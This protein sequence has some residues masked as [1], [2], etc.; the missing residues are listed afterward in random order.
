MAIILLQSAGRYEDLKQ[1]EEFGHT[2]WSRCEPG[3]A[4]HDVFDRHIC[5]RL[6]QEGGHASA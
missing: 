5:C 4:H 2:W 3:E 6:I 1:P